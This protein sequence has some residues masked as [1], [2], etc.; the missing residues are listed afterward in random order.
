MEP[1]EEVQGGM[2]FVEPT[3]PPPPPTQEV[4]LNFAKAV[5]III[6]GKPYYGKTIV[7]PNIE[8]AAEIVR[9]AREAYGS[10][11]FV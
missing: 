5:E 2:A 6:N 10:S 8:V 1:V 3:P 7:A 11:V 9:I 4:T